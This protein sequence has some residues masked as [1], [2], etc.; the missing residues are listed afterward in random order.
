MEL[1]VVVA[2]CAIHIIE[3]I[4]PVEAQQA[5]HRQIDADADT[6]RTLH[7]KRVES[8][9]PEPAVTRLQEGQGIDGGLWIQR[10]RI[11]HLQSVFCHNV[12]AIASRTGAA[13][14][15]RRQ[16][17]VGIA[18]HTDQLAAVERIVAQ[19]IAAK[20][21]TVERRGTDLVVVVAQIAEAHAGHHHKFLIKLGV[22]SGLESPAVHLNPFVLV[23]L[24][25]TVVILVVQQRIGWRDL[26]PK[27]ELRAV[28][29]IE[30]LAHRIARQYEIVAD[31]VELA[32]TIAHI[33]IIRVL[34]IV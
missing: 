25:E 16:R 23:I 13:V 32:V 30:R 1:A 7:I 10:E 14:E 15:A 4:A 2:L 26:K 3:A 31:Q 27:L 11:T 22:P 17:V 28:A 5:E 18:T 19:A 21:E 8:I 9:E 33:Q 29:R 34:V 20:E 6:S 24:R 12:T